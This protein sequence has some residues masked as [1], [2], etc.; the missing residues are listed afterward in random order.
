MTFAKL[1][2]LLSKDYTLDIISSSEHLEIHDVALLDNKHE[3]NKSILYFGYDKQ[4]GDCELIPSQCI[5][6]H[7]DKLLD[8][9]LPV[10]NLAF[11]PE[12][13]LFSIFNEA[14]SII[15]TRRS[16][17]I[18]K[19]LTKLADQTKSIEAVIDAASVSLGCSLLFCDMHFKIIASST[20]IPVIDPLWKDNIKQ[21]YCS[22]EFIKEVKELEPIRHASMNT[23]A[24]EVTC[25]S[26]PYRKLSCKVFH[27]RIQIGFLLLIEGDNRFLP[28][29]Y[30][31]L[32]TVSNIISYTISFHAKDLFE[33]STLYQQVLYDLLIGAPSDV[34]E[35]K[36]SGIHFPTK[37]CVLLIRPTKYLGRQYLKDFT[38]RNLKKYIPGTHVTYHKSGMVAV[39]PV[40]GETQIETDLLNA[41]K[42]FSAS[43]SVR[44]GISNSFSNIENFINYYNQ[45]NVALELGQKL[46]PEENVFSYLNY[47]VFDLFS[48]IKNPDQLGRFCHPALAILR[49]QDCK[50]NT[51]LY[52][53]L[54]TYLEKGCSIKLAAENLYIHRNSLVYRLNRITEL[55]SIDL[56]NTNSNFLL[57][58]SFLIDRYNKLNTI[59]IP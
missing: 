17:G 52:E 29:H 49:Q 12:E 7:K 50:N 26:S 38:Y 45:A 33:E 35:S 8:S 55:C 25:N 30:E 42:K 9:S 31:M 41:I 59:Q 24:V 39:I 16:K 6:A 21:G 57:R 22:Y 43:E 48:E 46:N 10:E 28:S 27:N 56:E 44:I 2:E 5:L 51:N 20:T 32:S 3:K 19:E 53:T 4:L 37:M 36:L 1:I 54:Y 58:L 11:V 14:K 13:S 23:A 15:E 40:K 18:Y 34:I 47:Q